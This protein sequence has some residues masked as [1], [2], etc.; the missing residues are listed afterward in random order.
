MKPVLRR[1]AIHGTVTAVILAVLG[2]LLVQL[3][4]I[5][6]AAQPNTKAA[7]GDPIPAPAGGDTV[8]EIRTRVPLLMAVW[9]VALVVVGELFLH[10]WRGRRP[11]APPPPPQPDPAEKLLEE[12]LNQVESKGTYPAQQESGARSQE[13]ETPPASPPPAAP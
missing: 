1:I 5:W 11:V 6:L 13:S 7:P 8:A 2:L 3:A 12:L 10:W 9:G 4:S